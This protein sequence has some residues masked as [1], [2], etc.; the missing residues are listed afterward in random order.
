MHV[1][2][3]WPN[4]LDVYI[5]L[6]SPEI[7]TY[8]G[9]TA[10]DEI[11]G[12][13]D[14]T[15]F[16]VAHLAETPPSAWIEANLVAGTRLGYDPWLHTPGEIKDLG[17]KLGDRATLVPSDNLVDRI[18]PDRPGAPVTLV[19]SLGNNRAGRDPADKLK[20]LRAALA[21]DNADAVVL[22]L[23]DSIC[24]LFNIRGRDVPNTPFVLG[25]AVIPKIGKP[26]F[27]VDRVKMN[28]ELRRALDGIASLADA[29]T[30][31]GALEKLGQDGKRVMI[32][33]ATIPATGRRSACPWSALWRRCR[34]R[35]RRR[36]RAATT[37]GR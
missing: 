3:G 33:P 32:D 36:G 10:I 29:R 17:E 7:N 34:R 31:I 21:K 23:P 28:P 8:A 2:C 5:D 16:T 6:Y 4:S 26:K 19:E 24:W 30:L 1:P 22:T 12:S 25:F 13:L 20:E 37:P 9:P 27:Y 15:I 35:W 14:T 18:W 11:S